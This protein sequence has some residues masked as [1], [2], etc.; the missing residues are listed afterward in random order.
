MHRKIDASVTPEECFSRTKPS[1]SLSDPFAAGWFPPVDLE[2]SLRRYGSSPWLSCSCRRSLVIRKSFFRGEV[3]KIISARLFISSFSLFV[4]VIAPLGA[5]AAPIE[6]CPAARSCSQA[7]SICE[8]GRNPGTC[9]AVFQ[10]CIQ[11]GEVGSGP[12]RC[13]VQDRR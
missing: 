7:K 11:T 4:A 8:T 2:K 3:M 1:L 10:T 13:T 5:F 9:Q 6:K 12:N